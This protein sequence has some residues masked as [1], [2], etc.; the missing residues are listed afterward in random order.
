M[1]YFIYISAICAANLSAYY[2]GPWV[3]PLNA[4]FLIGLDFV[5]R[6]QLHERIGFIKM[7]GLIIMAGLFS[8]L[9]NPASGLISLASVSAFLVANAADATIFQMLIKR[10]WM[11]KSNGSNIVGAAL[12]SVIFPLIAFGVFIPSVVVGQF[13]AKVFGG[14]VWS[15]IL[16]SRK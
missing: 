10:P 4:F 2:F 12:D 13:I 5:I 1:I 6:D 16:R 7:L 11:I 14:L 3:T 15:Y 8:F 9:V